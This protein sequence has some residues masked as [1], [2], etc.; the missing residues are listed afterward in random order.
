[1]GEDIKMKGYT[2][3]KEGIKRILMIFRPEKEDQ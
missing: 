2:G 3:K 1:M